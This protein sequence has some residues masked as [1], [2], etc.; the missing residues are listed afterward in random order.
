[1]TDVIMISQ[2]RYC[3]LLKKIQKSLIK[4]GVECSVLKSPVA[5]VNKIKKYFKVGYN[6]IPSIRPLKIADCTI[7]PE[8]YILTYENYKIPLRKKEFQFIQF[9]FENKNKILN[10]TIILENV[11]GPKNSFFTNTVDVHV[12]SLR[13]KLPK[14]LSEK[15][16]T[17]HGVGYK[18]EI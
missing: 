12:A 7:D 1:M 14:Q 9:L 10:R 15:I 2:G 6:K 13:K 11:W 5:A 4:D 17:I 3:K 18:L 8:E 16:K